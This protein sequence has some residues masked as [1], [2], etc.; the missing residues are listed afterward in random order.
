MARIAP[1]GVGGGHVYVANYIARTISQYTVGPT[2][3]LAPLS[4]PT[5]TTAAL[6]P[7]EL[8]LTPSG[9]NLY[10]SLIDPAGSGK[11]LLGEFSVAGDG[12]LTPLATPTIPTA[13]GPIEIVPTPDGK[14]L[15]VDNGTAGVISQYS[16]GPTGSLTALSPPTVVPAGGPGELTMSP[17]GNFLYSAGTSIS[18]FSINSA[19]GQ[20][21]ALSPATAGSGGT[22]MKITPDGKF[23]Y[24]GGTG[25]SQYSISANGQLSALTPAV[26][27]STLGALE[28][29][30]SSTG[31]FLYATA[32]DGQGKS[33]LEQFG[34]SANGQLISLVPA[35]VPTGNI[36]FEAVISPDGN[37]LYVGN[38]SFTTPALP[39]TVSQFSV[40]SNGTLASLSPA[41]VPTG[42]GAGA[43]AATPPTAVL[44]PPG[45]GPGGL[46]PTTTTYTGPST[47]LV[48]QAAPLSA[49][50]TVA[51]T[52]TP[53]PTMPIQL[54]LN[55]KE[56]CTATTKAD[57]TAA[58][59]V[60]PSEVAGTY[61]VTAVFAGNATYVASSASG[62][63][64]LHT[65]TALVAAPVPTTS[66][67]PP[68]T[69]VPQADPP[70]S[71]PTPPSLPVT[72]GSNHGELVGFAA[73]LLALL[74]REVQRR[75]TPT[76]S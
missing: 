54:V 28:L 40:G 31:K 58:C 6:A 26:A 16:I 20:L 12:A 35:L 45:G 15:Y 55:N 21:T 10:I 11:D 14:F 63:L 13:A 74:A 38:A 69:P 1:A 50:L 33:Q 60:T 57:G 73:V 65:T 37:F 72:G 52:S 32:I 70:V 71:L 34:I 29:E 22:D 59:S 8:E 36:A 64:L 18:Q 24:A 46:I 39:D 42:A 56:G 66:A 30:M 4:P 51:G 41:A 9:Q 44:A 47:G 5:L 67:V 68:T 17:S 25:V 23:L 7:G 48:G 2:G 62:R 19:T 53:I 27:S 61:T 3:N 76:R 49:K 43:L 75:S